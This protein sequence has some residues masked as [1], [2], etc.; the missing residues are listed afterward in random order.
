MCL[1]SS[2]YIA[3]L[4][5]VSTG[6]IT[7]FCATFRARDRVTVDHYAQ[8]HR[9]LY[10]SK[11]KNAYCH[12]NILYLGTFR[13]LRSHTQVPNLRR[14]DVPILPNP[15]V[16]LG[17]LFGP[18]QSGNLSN[19]MSRHPTMTIRCSLRCACRFHCIS[20]NLRRE[21]LVTRNLGHDLTTAGMC[22]YQFVAIAHG[23]RQSPPVIPVHGFDHPRKLGYGRFDHLLVHYFM[24]K[25]QIAVVQVGR[26]GRSLS[27]GGTAPRAGPTDKRTRRL[28]TVFI[29]PL[30]LHKHP[31][32][33]TKLIVN[34]V[35]GPF[36]FNH[37]CIHFSL[38][39]K[40]DQIHFRLEFL[41]FPLKHKTPKTQIDNRKRRWKLHRQLSCSHYRELL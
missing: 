3:Q 19:N 21:A 14:F 22:H 23:R 29:L 30:R 11:R 4:A 16:R 8:H 31:S 17:L 38:N 35:H 5:Y 34:L 9:M 26:N 10:V 7:L 24:P 12:S 27:T 13:V 20:E 37:K 36:P 6:E 18:R 32:P 1:A 39:S 40:D 15:V 33:G 41:Q 2:R 25:A 28:I